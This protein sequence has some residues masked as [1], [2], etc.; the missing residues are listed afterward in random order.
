MNDIIQF[1]QYVYTP[2]ISTTLSQN[3]YDIMKK[4]PSS[5]KILIKLYEYYHT[6]TKFSLLLRTNLWRIQTDP[7]S[8]LSN[9]LPIEI[10]NIIDSYETE[11]RLNKLIFTC[12]QYYIC[13]IL[14]QLEEE[15][16]LHLYTMNSV[17]I[18]TNYLQFYYAKQSTQHCNLLQR[19]VK[20]NV[21]AYLSC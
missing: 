16:K 19:Q 20:E 18:I 2:N 5:K 8:S 7:I 11:T 10:W 1:A 14:F 21:H 12:K 3:Y 15:Y 13:N 17:S 4:L 9:I 6:H